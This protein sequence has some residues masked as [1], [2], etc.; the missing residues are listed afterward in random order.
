MSC[1]DFT[2]LYTG[3]VIDVVEDILL[4]NGTMLHA[5][6]V[7]TSCREHVELKFGDNAIDVSRGWWHHLRP[8]RRLQT[9]LAVGR[10]GDT[11]LVDV[12]LHGER[13]SLVDAVFLF[14]LF[15][16]ALTLYYVRCHPFHSTFFKKMLLGYIGGRLPG[17]NTKE[18][19]REVE[20]AEEEAER[21]VRRK[22]F[23]KWHREKGKGAGRWQADRTKNS[24]AKCKAK[25]GLLANR[26]RRRGGRWKCNVLRMRSWTKEGKGT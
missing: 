15:F 2:P 24:W 5:G 3:H 22:L 6:I 10:R 20:K 8:R 21:Q 7:T 9:A 4:N 19:D 14:V 17:R 12:V 23:K 13:S 18:A 25:L 26:K 1:R 11:C 16:S